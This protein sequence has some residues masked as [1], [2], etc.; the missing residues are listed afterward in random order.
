MVIAGA[1]GDSMSTALVDLVVEPAGGTA[2]TSIDFVGSG[3]A[4][5]KIGTGGRSHQRELE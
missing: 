5:A 2:V 1:N 3:T 4:M